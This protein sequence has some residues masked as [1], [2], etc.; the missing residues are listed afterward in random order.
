MFDIKLFVTLLV[1]WAV[2]M[3]PRFIR[4]HFDDRRRIRR[5]AREIELIDQAKKIGPIL[6]Q[7]IEGGIVAFCTARDFYQAEKMAR[8]TEVWKRV[9]VEVIPTFTFASN[10]GVRVGAHT[11]VMADA[12][13]ILESMIRR[14][15]LICKGEQIPRKVFKYLIH[16]NE[17]LHVPF[18]PATDDIDRFKRELR[19]YG[20][21]TVEQA[22][23]NF[24]KEC[25]NIIWKG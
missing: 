17:R 3:L 24:L 9:R 10:E 19:D 21:T 22:E 7:N 15:I 13:L 8:G 18:L 25:L 2:I 20:L 1:F 12:E 6:I 16:K 23:N 5:M 14:S 4:N 11:G